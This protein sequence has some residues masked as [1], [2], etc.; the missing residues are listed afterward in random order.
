MKA[1]ALNIVGV[2]AVVGG[3]VALYFGGA[4][5][6]MVTELIGGVFMLIGLIVPFFKKG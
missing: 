2:V 6:G 5:E 1:N 3:A 4:S